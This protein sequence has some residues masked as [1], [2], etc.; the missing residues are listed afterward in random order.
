MSVRVDACSFVSVC[1]P[2]LAFFEQIDS[3]SSVR[4]VIPKDLLPVEARENTL[5][6]VSEVLSRFAKDGLPQLDPEDDMKVLVDFS[7]AQVFSN[8]F[9]ILSF[10][11]FL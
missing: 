8:Q 1:L 7:F 5:K 3:L 6:K 4:L 10:V 11:A 9:D 2:D